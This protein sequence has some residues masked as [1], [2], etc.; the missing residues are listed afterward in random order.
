VERARR[1]AGHTNAGSY[2]L[3]DYGFF[4]AALRRNAVDRESV[5]TTASRSIAPR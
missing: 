2:H 1:G 5:W 3:N 4:Y